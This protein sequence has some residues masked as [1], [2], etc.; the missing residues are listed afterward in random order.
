MWDDGE[1]SVE[2][3]ACDPIREIETEPWDFWDAYD[4]PESEANPDDV[5]TGLIADWLH[6]CW[7]RS[8]GSASKLRFYLYA[9]YGHCCHDLV[10]GRLVDPDEMKADLNI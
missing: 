3:I 2:V 9:Y 5:L 8:G 4:L 7:I 6:D 1:G 10:K